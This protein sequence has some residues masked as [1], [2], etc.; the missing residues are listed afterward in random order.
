VRGRGSWQRC[1]EG[2]VIG[3]SCSG[4][5]TLGGILARRLDLPYV[6]LDAL[7]HGPNWTE[8]S[9]SSGMETASRSATRSS[10]ATHFWRMR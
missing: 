8:A 4:K 6:E 3:V 1:E 9:A 10:D 5:T 2:L 7:H